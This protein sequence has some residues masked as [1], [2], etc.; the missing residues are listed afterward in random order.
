M[1]KEMQTKVDGYARVHKSL[2]NQT[3]LDAIDGY[4]WNAD[5]KN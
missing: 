5:R 2:L 3:K 1:T 4:K